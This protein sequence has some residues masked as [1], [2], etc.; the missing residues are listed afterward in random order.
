MGVAHKAEELWK[1][2]AGTRDRFY[3][4]KAQK[5]LIEANYHE[6]KIDAK[7]A[8]AQMERLRFDWR[9]DDLELEI[10]R[11]I[12]DLHADAG[13]YPEAFETMKRAISLFPDRPEAQQIAKQ[14]TGTFAGLF[15]K[16]GA[17]ALS[18]VDALSLYE[19]YRE[20]TPVGAEG[21]A[22][23]RRL[24][25]RLVEIDL[26]DRAAELLG[27][28]VEFRL[29]G[30]EKAQV[31]T[32]LAGIRLLNNQPE[33]AI[34]AL[35]KSQVAGI[36]PD[37]THDRLLLRARALSRMGKSREAID[38]LAEDRSQPANLLRIDIAW[39]DKQWGPAAVALADLIGPPP[40]A[41]AKVDPATAK[42]VVNRA[43]AMSQAGDV[44]GLQKLR[45]DF[46][47]AMEGTPEGN[48]FLLMTRPQEAA[49]LIDA[50]SIQA[51]LAEIDM[52]SSFL[53]TYR[54]REDLA[55]PPPPPIPTAPLPGAEPKDGEPVPS[56]AAPGESGAPD[57][58]PAEPA[59]AA[60][61][62]AAPVEHETAT[63]P[64]AAELPK[65]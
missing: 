23:I 29:A 10:L 32:R 49:G 54:K 8:V 38:L 5:A 57:H 24:A 60:A 39:R 20:L 18:P 53:S 63:P 61:Q 25:E 65:H 35:D 2:V 48:A 31:G 41:G 15:L 40:A 26:L 11:R 55:T 47:K 59:P 9:G 62:G 36:P 46:G 21:D 6:H 16:D 50:A 37:L 22:V 17:A 30:Q 1:E 14:M 19:Q 45:T 42:L 4:T 58:E 13:Q 52:F 51:R 3:R 56:A 12:G 64:Q 7:Q 28:Q 33:E 43:I 34:T 44:A 27:H